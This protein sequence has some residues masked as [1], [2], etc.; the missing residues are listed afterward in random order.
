[1][2]VCV[3]V[4]VYTGD[5]PG[6]TRVSCD[7]AAS[8][9]WDVIPMSSLCNTPNMDSKYP[10]ITEEESLWLPAHTDRIHIQVRALRVSCRV[11]RRAFTPVKFLHG[12]VMVIRLLPLT[13]TARVRSPTRER[14]WNWFMCYTCCN[15]ASFELDVRPRSSLCSTPN[16]DYKDPDITEEA[17]LW[18]RV[19]TDCIN[20][21]VSALNVSCRVSRRGFC[22]KFP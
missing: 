16:I 4:C 5:E 22:L 3:C 13:P 9:G 20:I 17:I 8:F 1:M 10:D 18:L 12:G 14:S 21:Q 19:H 2:C 6:F 15:A 7:N 11:N